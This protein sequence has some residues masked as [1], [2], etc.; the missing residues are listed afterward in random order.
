M[1]KLVVVSPI[2]RISIIYYIEVG[3]LCVSDHTPHRVYN[4][5]QTDIPYT[6]AHKHTHT[7][8][9]TH[10][11]SS[12]HRLLHVLEQYTLTVTIDT[13]YYGPVAAED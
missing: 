2:F 10:T 6:H 7:H 9:Y 11:H 5:N 13:L 1:L 8:T 4:R 12:S 3:L